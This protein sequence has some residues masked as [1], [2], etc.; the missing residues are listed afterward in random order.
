M[1]PIHS[2]VTSTPLDL[3]TTVKLHNHLSLL[4]PLN[5]NAF[6]TDLEVVTTP[7]KFKSFTH[8]KTQE[9]LFHEALHRLVYNFLKHTHEPQD[10]ISAALLSLSKSIPARQMFDTSREGNL[11]AYVYVAVKRHTI[12]SNRGSQKA[13]ERACTVYLADMVDEGR[14]ICADKAEMVFAPSC[15]GQFVELGALAYNLKIE[16]DVLNV[17]LGLNDLNRQITALRI[18]HPHLD[19]EAVG[20]CCTPELSAE[21]VGQRWYAIRQALSR[22]HPS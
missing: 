5:D 17:L 9:R 3:D 12:N 18:Y 11:A 4:F 6:N 21:Q 19:L 1:I 22:K 8:H 14:N 7:K 15:V 16:L 2:E 13:L 20:K 10:A